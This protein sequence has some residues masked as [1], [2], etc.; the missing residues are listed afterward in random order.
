MASYAGA[1]NDRFIPCR[2]G[3]RFELA[4]EDFENDG[5][6]AAVAAP[7]D[8]GRAALLRAELLGGA[9]PPCALGFSP[10]KPRPASPRA[11]DGAA[12]RPGGDR[13]GG[14]GGEAARRRRIQGAPF[15][16]LDAPGLSDD[17]YLDL[18]HWSSSNVLAVGL[19]SKVYLRSPRSAAREKG[20]TCPTSLSFVVHSF[21]LTF[22]RAI[23][24]RNGLEAWVL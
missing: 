10:A 20:A 9:R 11:W 7:R 21:R 1:G 4:R 5:P 6:A 14:G 13:G 16:V 18:V 12:P 2:S 3:S 23:I 15:K 8:G 22:G 19:G 17:F 24:S